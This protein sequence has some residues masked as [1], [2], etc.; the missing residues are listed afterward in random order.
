MSIT[1]VSQGNEIMMKTIQ[2]GERFSVGD[3]IQWIAASGNAY[4]GEVETIKEG[5]DSRGDLLVVKLFSGKYR[6]AYDNLNDIEL[7][8]RVA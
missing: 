4:I 7:L 2:V 3:T 1:Q 5:V 8:D 6:N